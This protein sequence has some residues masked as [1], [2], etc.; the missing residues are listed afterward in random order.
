M[1]KSGLAYET[2]W[3][4]KVV[5]RTEPKLKKSVRFDFLKFQYF[6]IKKSSSFDPQPNRIVRLGFRFKIT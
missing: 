6:L 4:H 2:K 3:S 1:A 5:G